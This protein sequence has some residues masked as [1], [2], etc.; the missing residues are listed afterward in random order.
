MR[1]TD[2]DCASRNRA[3]GRVLL[4]SFFPRRCPREHNK[5]RESRTRAR[6]H[7]CPKKSCARISYSRAARRATDATIPSHSKYYVSCRPV[8][9]KGRVAV[10][11]V[12][13]RVAEEAGVA[14]GGSVGYARPR[15]ARFSLLFGK[16]HKA[17]F[18]FK[19]SLALVC[20]SLSRWSA[21]FLVPFLYERAPLVRLTRT[22]F[23]VGTRRRCS[24][25][26][27]RRLGRPSSSRRTGSSCAKI[28]SD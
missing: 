11:A 13:K 16:F 8:H 17:I 5:S 14:L 4:F 7:P 27:R 25:S 22:R 15:G 24:S 28:F 9:T 2:A 26:S 20:V 23:A 3:R 12:A 6:G 1:A 10:L 21:A 19:R 18:D